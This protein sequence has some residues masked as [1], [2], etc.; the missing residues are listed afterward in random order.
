M[1]STIGTT[2]RDRSRRPPA[3]ARTMTLRGA[4]RD[5][6]ARL[7]LAIAFPADLAAFAGAS[8]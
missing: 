4:R 8:L 7:F 3:K 1:R 5:K 6:A 2:K